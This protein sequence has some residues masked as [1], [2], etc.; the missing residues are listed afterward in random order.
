MAGFYP[1]NAS[2]FDSDAYGVNTDNPER[3]YEIMMNALTKE[4]ETAIADG[5]RDW[6]KDTA[7]EYFDT[8]DWD[9][10]EWSDWDEVVKEI[11]F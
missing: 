10:E 4:C 1:P 7:R 9:D 6:M 5:Y 8:S 11:T 2:I 3:P